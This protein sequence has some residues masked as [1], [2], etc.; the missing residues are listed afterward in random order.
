M[1]KA[2]GYTKFGMQRHIELWKAQDGKAKPQ[3][4]LWGPN[5]RRLVLV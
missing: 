1:M 2:E 4:G 3:V 5:R